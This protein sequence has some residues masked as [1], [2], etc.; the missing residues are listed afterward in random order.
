MVKHVGFCVPEGNA[1]A[2]VPILRREEASAIGED[3]IGLVAIQ[4]DRFERTQRAHGGA[5]PTIAPLVQCPHHGG[6]TIWTGRRSRHRHREGGR[7][8][9]TERQRQRE[10]ERELKQVQGAIL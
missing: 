6:L 4:D 2:A 1:A 10:T 3:H 7:E 5:H 9:E 8:R